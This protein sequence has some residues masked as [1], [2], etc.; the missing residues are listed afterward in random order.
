MST[1]AQLEKDIK[2]YK[3][4]L[5]ATK[6]L[7]DSVTDN[8]IKYNSSTGRLEYNMPDALNE[9]KFNE[10]LPENQ[11]KDK[12]FIKYQISKYTR[13]GRDYKGNNKV[14]G[15][16]RSTNNETRMDTRS[17]NVKKRRV[18]GNN[19]KEQ[20]GQEVIHTFYVDV[21][22][23]VLEKPGRG[24]KDWAKDGK[25]FSNAD[26]VYRAKKIQNKIKNAV[27]D[28]LG[29][30]WKVKRR[31]ESGLDPRIWNTSELAGRSKRSSNYFFAQR[32]YESANSGYAK[33]LKKF[34]NEGREHNEKIDLANE[35]NPQKNEY[36]RQIN[37]VNREYNRV[38]NV[39]KQ[40]YD[41]AIQIANQTKGA[42]Y[43]D[44]RDK[45][46]IIKKLEEAGISSENS[47]KILGDV[48]SAF[49]DFYRGEKLQKFDFGYGQEQGYANTKGKP[50][51]GAFDPNYYRQQTLP[52]QSLTEQEKWNEAVANDDIDIIERFGEGTGAEEGYYLWRYGQQRGAGELRG[53]AADPLE[54]A[55]E[56]VEKAPTD[57]EMQQ[58]RDKMLKIEEDD[59][60]TLINDVNYIKEAYEE[61]KQAKADGAAN[62]FV[63]AAGTYFNI[64]NPDEF[65]LVFQ[66]SENEDD[67]KAY[68]ELKE[69]GLYITELEDAITGVVGEETLLQTKKFGALSQNVL[70]DT[71]DQLRR[72]KAKEQEL[73]LMGQFSTFGEIMDVNKSLTDS[74]LGDTGIGG[75]LPFMG[76]DSGLDSKT[77]EKQLSGVTG[78]NNNVVYN[79]QQW[80]DD[81]IKKNY[82]EFED[83]YLEL[84]YTREEAEEAAQEQV[85][86]QKSFAESYITDYLKPRF[87]E[88]RSMNEFVEYLDVRQEEQNPFQTQSLLNAVNEVGQLQADA[89]L[90]KIRETAVDKKFNSDFYFDPVGAGRAQGL[91]AQY[92]NQKKIV[93]EDWDK[94]RNN[95]NQIADSLNPGQ[96]TWAELAYRYGAD[97]N[98]KQEFAKLHYQVKGKNPNYKFDPAEDVINAG[99]VK[100]HIYR[101]ILPKLVEEAENQ[102]TIFGQFVR[103][104]E[105]AEDM[106][107]G[108]DPNQPDEWNE[109]LEQVGLSDFQGTTN[110]LK[111]YIAETFRTGSAADIRAQ[112]KYLNEKREKPTQQ[113]L[114]VEYIQREED[115]KT[116]AKLQGDTQ[117]FK[118]F[119]DAGYEGTEDD[120]YEN[121]FPDLDRG[122]QTLLSQ[123]GESGKV[124]IEGLGDD[125]RKNPFAA[126]G[127]ISGLTG[128]EG[129]IFGTQQKEKE[130]EKERESSYFTFD[131]DYD[132]EEE[133]YKSKKGKEILGQFTKGFSSFI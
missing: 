49:K 124:S 10:N 24:L 86:I 83:D 68:N 88:S 14:L 132:D 16:M 84:G 114:G 115:Y 133:D 123:V 39:K 73:A 65:L 45:I 44:Q 33:A 2:E 58:I 23:I 102:P 6:G 1:R 63:D 82:S 66:Q 91:Q 15:F 72:A 108:L 78:I 122:S 42:D 51:Y 9:N 25:R 89:Y 69:S 101:N 80:F 26:N 107:E 43:T 104:E 12:V 34:N 18:F 50:L 29:S 38:N 79:W 112:L 92:D 106:I 37:E 93:E 27:T 100:D 110:D 76:K 85:N 60:E 41:D 75:F 57:A 4:A 67:Q 13:N 105:F 117:L 71:F 28:K 5:E 54:A 95:P 8:N 99:K 94:A 31:T 32:S 52:N 103:P 130:P 53:N 74:L 96:G 62:R 17:V 127:A 87:D 3:Q 126:F 118:V 129:G 98:N 64:D 59:P 19:K 48:E 121:V 70:K 113:L 36:A 120:F 77:L 21:S 47:Q 131:V 55:E 128:D 61:A 116:T 109:A 22:D 30:T 35:F 125:Y 11:A 90:D 20:E 7:P 111:N 97:V 40:T 56:F 119:Q 46:R 81:S